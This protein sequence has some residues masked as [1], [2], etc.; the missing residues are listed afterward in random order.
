MPTCLNPSFFYIFYPMH[1]TL[2]DSQ[3]HACVLLIHSRLHPVA[4]QLL[5]FP[6]VSS[7]FQSCLKSSGGRWTTRNSQPFRL[8]FTIT[9]ANLTWTVL[10]DLPSVWCGGDHRQLAP[11]G[12]ILNKVGIK[13][14]S[15]KGCVRSAFPKIKT[16]DTHYPARGRQCSTFTSKGLILGWSLARNGDHETIKAK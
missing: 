13:S 2:R 4:S 9:V 15:G 16:W 7:T 5:W 10:V 8:S 6:V 1:T 11:D 14:F 3:L 12:R